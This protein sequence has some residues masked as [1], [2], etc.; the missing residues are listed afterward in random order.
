MA[1]SWTNVTD[2][3]P[4]LSTVALA[5]QTALLEQVNEEE[6]SDDNWPSEAKADRARAYLAAHLATLINRRGSA[7]AVM[8]E[9]VGSVSR[10]YST[11]VAA[12]ANELGSTSYGMN[13]ERLCHNVAAFRFT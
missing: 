9:S 1:I 5:T 2:I 7:G 3:A 12:G 4:E 11:S 8:S 13:Y 6:I 10:A